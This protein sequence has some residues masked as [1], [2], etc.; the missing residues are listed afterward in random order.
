MNSPICEDCRHFHQHDVKIGELYVP[1][2]H[3]HCDCKPR[4][5]TYHK[6]TIHK[7]RKT[8]QPACKRYA[9]RLGRG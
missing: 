2:I 5:R 8:E 1:T 9:D 6:I 4:A 3:G 7:T